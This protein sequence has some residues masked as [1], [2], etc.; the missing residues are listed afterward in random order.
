[1]LAPSAARCPA[2]R[3]VGGGIVRINL[4]GKGMVLR[5]DATVQ[6]AS[7]VIRAERS[8]VWPKYM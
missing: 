3:T 1:M 4:E 7:P 5:F 8:T 6:V 2:S